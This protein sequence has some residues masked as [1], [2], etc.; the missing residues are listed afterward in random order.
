MKASEKE[1]LLLHWLKT[2]GEVFRQRIL[3]ACVALSRFKLILF[4]SFLPAITV[5]ASFSVQKVFSTEKIYT[6]RF[7]LFVFRN[8]CLGQRENSCSSV[9]EELGSFFT[10]EIDF[11]VTTFHLWL[12]R[13]FEVPGS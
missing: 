11:R 12:V 2:L 7:N 5:K 9:Y 10:P 4:I 3:A 1:L 8:D 13:M 6:F